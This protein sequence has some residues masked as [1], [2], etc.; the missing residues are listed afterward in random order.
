MKALGMCLDKRVVTGAVIAVGLVWWFAPSLL[1]EAL[2]LLLLAICPV[3]MLLMMKMMKEQDG[4]V[5][6]ATQE[7]TASTSLPADAG[8]DA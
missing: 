6:Q 2:P 4:D 1:A 8:S 7:A 5:R 3:S